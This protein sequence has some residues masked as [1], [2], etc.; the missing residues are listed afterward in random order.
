[1]EE[2]YKFLLLNDLKLYTD[3]VLYLGRKSPYLFKFKDKNYK[4]LIK[5]ITRGGNGRNRLDER[6]IQISAK[7]KHDL[8]SLTGYDTII[9]GY[10]HDNNIYSAWN[11]CIF[12]KRIIK[13]TVSLFTSIVAIQNANSTHFSTYNY[14][15][16][17][18]VVLNFLPEY[19]GYYF[20]N[21]S[22]LHQIPEIES[23][24]YVEV[25]Q[26]NRERIHY[27]GY[28]LQRNPMFRNNVYRA[29]DG[30]CA[31]CG[32]QLGLVEAAHIIPHCH[33]SSS[34]HITN[35]I[36]LCSLH[37]KAYDTSLIYFSQDYE[38]KLNNLLITSLT[39][40][41]RAGGLDIIS[42]IANR[43][44]LLPDN[45]FDHPDRDYLKLGNELRGLN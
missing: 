7:N 19:L 33:E 35:G 11:P 22:N 3:E 17:T 1:M 37:H 38:V 28:Q 21:Y 12:N 36:C 44:L 16:R 26:I 31:I 24:P 18:E 20:D 42:N 34:D 23:F 10:D 2:F 6:R 30:K 41:N 25:G 45:E 5:K 43:T 13:S 14:A 39:D 9:L 4:V 29:Y 8:N 32:I 40:L 15:N 27:Q